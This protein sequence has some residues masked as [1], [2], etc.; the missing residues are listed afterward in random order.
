MD[1]DKMID[2]LEEEL[3][4]Q[5]MGHVTAIEVF[6]GGTQN[7]LNY[8]PVLVDIVVLDYDGRVIAY[9]ISTDSQDDDWKIGGIDSAVDEAI[10]YYEQILETEKEIANHWED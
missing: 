10:G 6:P 7:G 1:K 3:Y 9:R 8:G 5:E 4:L 2:S